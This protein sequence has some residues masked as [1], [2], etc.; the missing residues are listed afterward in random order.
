MTNNTEEIMKL[1]KKLAVDS[2]KAGVLTE[3]N[4]ILD[5]LKSYWCGELNCTKHATDW[6]KLFEKILEP[7]DD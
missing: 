2:A 5:L 6:V 7:Q 4:R 1:A 3:R